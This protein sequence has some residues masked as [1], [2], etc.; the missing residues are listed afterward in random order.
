MA[1]IFKQESSASDQAR[2]ESPPR[3][4]SPKEEVLTS[5][6]KT[7][8]RKIGRGVTDSS[9]VE[10]KDDGKGIFKTEGYENERGAYLIDRFLG[11]NLT[12]PTAIRVLD[13]EMGS[14]QEFIPD[15]ATFYEL[16]D[17]QPRV[18]VDNINEKHKLDFM[19]MWIFDIIIGNN[20]R[21]DGNFLIQ[22][23]ILY[24]IDHGRSLQYNRDEFLEY[25]DLGKGYKK[26]F[27]QEIPVELIEGIKFFLS[28]PEEQEILEDL[29]AE[30]FNRK[31]ASACLKR[32]RTI[33]EMLIRDGKVN[34]PQGHYAESSW[35]IPIV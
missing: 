23:D 18:S 26:F 15:A 31:Y 6:E 16:V 28:R 8:S 3:V 14:M 21:H 12:P 33:G 7:S 19:K 25:I 17:S 32:I 27:D 4:K 10:L 30:I 13:G 5:R 11:F 22:G 1:E 24:A 29:L 2:P 34:R 9:F 20:D 35:H